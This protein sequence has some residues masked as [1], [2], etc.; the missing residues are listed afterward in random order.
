MLFCFLDN[1]GK[2]SGAIY[3]I[4]CDQ[5]LANFGKI[6]K[7]KAYCI[8]NDVIGLKQLEK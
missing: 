2:K 1:K 8:H 5:K 7:I 3:T 4:N 6:S